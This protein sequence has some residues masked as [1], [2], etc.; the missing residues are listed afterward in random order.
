MKILTKM[1]QHF[2]IKKAEIIKIL[3]IIYVKKLKKQIFK[4]QFR[5]INK[6]NNGNKIQIKVIFVKLKTVY[7]TKEKINE[8]AKIFLM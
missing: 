7:F 6:L 5:L 1:F 4:K 3:Q 8:K 2:C